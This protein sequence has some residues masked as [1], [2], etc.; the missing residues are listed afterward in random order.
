MRRRDGAVDSCLRLLGL[1]RYLE[2]HRLTADLGSARLRLGVWI[3]ISAPRSRLEVGISVEV[4]E[5]VFNAAPCYSVNSLGAGKLGYVPHK[6]IPIIEKL[7][8]SDARL[9]AVDL[10]G[11][12][13]KRY[14]VKVHGHPR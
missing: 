4:K 5:E 10:G 12:P 2:P 6:L 8:I 9:C 3:T 7:H 1:R 11:V 14:E 13:W